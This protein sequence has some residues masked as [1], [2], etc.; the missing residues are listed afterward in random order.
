MLLPATVSIKEVRAN[1]AAS[2]YFEVR[3][4]LRLGDRSLEE[5]TLVERRGSDVVP[6]QRQRVSQQ[7]GT[8]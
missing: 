4:R 8:K 2:T 1:V 7:A 3:G 6:L 5:M